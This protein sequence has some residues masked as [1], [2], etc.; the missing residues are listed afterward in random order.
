[1]ICQFKIPVDVES[2]GAIFQQN[3]L[4][5]AKEA[6]AGNG[7]ELSWGMVSPKFVRQYYMNNIEK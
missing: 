2:E 7:D 4:G 3:V 1:M 6:G 5:K